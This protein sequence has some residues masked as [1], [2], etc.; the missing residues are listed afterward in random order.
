MPRVPVQHAFPPHSA[1]FSLI[2]LIIVIVLL[3]ILAV[4]GM[5]LLI[6]PFLANEAVERRVGLADAADQALRA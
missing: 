3:G 5:D 4:V 6:Q 1:G 2:E